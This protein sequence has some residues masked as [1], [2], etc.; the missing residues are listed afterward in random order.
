ML[1]LRSA[2]GYETSNRDRLSWSIQFDMK[3]QPSQL[4]RV[5]LP[6]HLPFV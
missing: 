2:G 3:M 6:L 5:A 1:R 4:P